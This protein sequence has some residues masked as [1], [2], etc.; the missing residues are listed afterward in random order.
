MKSEIVTGNMPKLW[1]ELLSLLQEKEY[2]SESIRH[3]REAVGRIDYYMRENR[4]FEYTEAVGENYLAAHD[5]RNSNGRTYYMAFHVKRLNDV[6]NNRPYA[7]IHT[8]KKQ[9]ELRY[10]GKIFAD[11]TKML[12]KQPISDGTCKLQGRYGYEFLYF[13]EQRGISDPKEINAQ[14]IYAAFSASGSKE[15]FGCAVRKLLTYLYQMQLCPVNL[16]E[17]VPSVRR[18]KPMPSIYSRDEID[19]ILETVD[20]NNA[21]GLRDRAILL[22][23]ARLGI[24]VSDI[25][26]LKISDVHWETNTIEFVQV[27]TGVFA[28]LELLPD[29]K[30]AL[31]AYLTKGRPNSES[32]NVFLRAQCP[33][34]PIGRTV[35]HHAMSR[36]LAKAGICA[37]TR[38]TGSHALRMSLA[39]ELIAED[40]PYSVVHKVLGHQSDLCFNN[41]V[42][43]DVENLRR[44]AIAVPPATGKLKDWLGNKEDTFNGK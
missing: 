11:F 2:P 10:F 27:K 23:A 12:S 44:C 1:E 19:T 26:N 13:I 37:G 9:N 24:R 8:R 29:V 7:I 34:T 16:A 18:A 21:K 3:Y 41:Y 22:L 20:K 5:K 28:K 6:L 25:C 42:R 30:E 17:F 40:I 15:N 38:K 39:T 31:L 33:F 35:A 4:I 43:L 36:Y 14:T 32:T